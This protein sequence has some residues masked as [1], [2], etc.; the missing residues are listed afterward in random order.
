M[1]GDPAEP[2]LK[3]WSSLR[4]ALGAALLTLLTMFIA[5]IVMLFIAGFVYGAGS[6]GHWILLPMMLGI[7][8]LKAAPL[9]IVLVLV[10]RDKQVSTSASLVFGHVLLVMVFILFG[11]GILGKD[12]DLGELSWLPIGAHALILVCIAWVGQGQRTSLDGRA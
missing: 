5:W 10:L 1:I 11:S 12:N 7:I 9:I 8:E 4:G 6:H 2:G 3:H